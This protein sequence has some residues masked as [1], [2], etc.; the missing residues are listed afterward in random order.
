MEPVI[1]RLLLKYY[2][3][4]QGQI[5][6]SGID[7]GTKYS[8][9]A[10]CRGH[11][12]EIIPIEKGCDAIP[13][14]VAFTD[15]GYL[16]GNAAKR[17]LPSNPQNTIVDV[18]RLV[19]RNY[20]DP[21]VQTDVRFSPLH[22]IERGR[23]LM[24]EVNIKGQRKCFTP[25]E[26]LGT[27]L[28]HLKECTGTYL[29]QFVEKA[30]ITVPAGFN[31]AQRRATMN[32]G[33]MAG[34]TVLRLLNETAAA[35]I[36]HGLK[37]RR[38]S[39]LVFSIGKGHV[40]ASLLHIDFPLFRVVSTRGC[41][42]L[43]GKDLDMRIADY[44]KQVLEKRRTDA[45]I[46]ASHTL[47]ACERA[48]TI[49]SFAE[50]ASVR[51]HPLRDVT[52]T[53]PVITRA[54]FEAVCQDDFTSMKRLIEEVQADGRKN[55]TPVYDIILVGP[56]SRIPKIQK[57]MSEVFDGVSITLLYSDAVVRGAASQGAALASM[58]D[59]AFILQDV[60]P[61]SISIE[62]DGRLI[63]LVRCNSWIPLNKSEII[64]T[65]YDDQTGL[66]IGVFEGVHHSNPIGKF[67]LDG[68]QRAPR[69]RPRIE[70]TVYLDSDGITSVLA[71][72]LG[73]INR[74]QLAVKRLT[75]RDDILS[76]ISAVRETTG[77]LHWSDREIVTNT[78]GEV[79]DWVKSKFDGATTEE[80][81]AQVKWLTM[82]GSLVA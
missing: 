47:L 61:R 67:E 45:D 38:S 35:A 77:T 80:I 44:V 16:F 17:Q 8:R 59:S 41:T 73:S 2:S 23:R 31:D 13:S 4:Y 69:G 26:I 28:S 65:R 14:I 75:A 40:E 63:P 82:Y 29:G 33:R 32:A 21:V 76:H 57:I 3:S 6:D 30:V 62:A 46:L 43:G 51:I 50:K 7:L 52:E 54:R 55:S 72:E 12:V 70:L 66:L 79:D 9:V 56:A 74:T 19:G 1:G 25:E 81:A 60:T 58:A 15:N 20:D 48:R 39:T 68:L 53:H 37:S 11:Q 5:E 34:L 22:V 49:L 10:I 78:L 71:A 27:L 24:I 64:T 18:K 36:T 42:H